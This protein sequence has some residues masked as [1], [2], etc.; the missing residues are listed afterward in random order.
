MKILAFAIAAVGIALM[1]LGIR[2]AHANSDSL[3]IGDEGQDTTLNPPPPP[4]P[5]Q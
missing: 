1:G 4:H 3:Y 5:A 2:G